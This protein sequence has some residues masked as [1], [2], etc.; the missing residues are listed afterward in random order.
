LAR[1]LASKSALLALP[2]RDKFG[3]LDREIGLYRSFTYH[4]AQIAGA[5]GPH[6][7]RR[8]RLH[9]CYGPRRF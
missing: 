2:L 7:R 4:I 3:D 1:G 9:H 8:F 5:R 6:V